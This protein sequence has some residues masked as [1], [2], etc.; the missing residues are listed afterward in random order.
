MTAVTRSVRSL[1]L[2]LAFAFIAAPAAR[3]ES[4]FKAIFDG[5]TLDGWAG[6]D[7]LW[8]VKDGAIVGSTKPSG[9]KGNTFLVYEKALTDFVLRIEFKLLAGNSGVQFRSSRVGN[10]ADYVISGYQADIGENYFGCL[11]D[12]KRRGMLQETDRAWLA[13]FLKKGEWNSYEIRAQG[14]KITL[15]INGLQTVE[16]IEKDDSM[17]RTGL[18]AL[19]LHGGGPMEVHFRNIQLQEIAKPKLLYVTTAAG[20]AHRSRPHSREVLKKLGIDSGLFEATTTDTTDLISPQGLKDFDAVM[21][22]TTGDLAQFPLSKENREYLIQWVKDGH[23]FIGVHSATDTYKDWQ[24]F[25]EMIG[26]SFQAHPWNANDPAITIDVE[27]PSHPAALDVPYGW[28]IQDEIYEFKNYA[29]S[30]L[31]IILSMNPE[32]AAGKGSRPDRDF[33][34]AW[35]REFGKGKVFY[36]SLGHRSDVWDNPIYQRHLTGGIGWALGAPGYEGDATPGLAKP[37]NQFVALFDGSSLSGW[38][39]NEYER[40]DT[41]RWVISD[42]GVVVGLPTDAKNGHGHL[43]SPRQYENFHYKADIKIIDGGNSGMYFRA[44]KGKRWPDGFEAQINST[45]GDPVRSGS[46]YHIHKVFEQMAK[47]N[48]WFT[49]E[50]IAYGGHIVIRVN[51]KLATK[52]KTPV[53]GQEGLDYRKGHFAF[54]FHDPKCHVELRNVMVREL[55][56]LER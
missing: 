10:P 34:I 26:G 8:S 22:Y 32:S 44:S 43:F 42:E 7:G 15:E 4:E 38:T 40:K 31:H 20:Y 2:F 16:Y 3:G 21:F 41:A 55:P 29:R 6:L 48:E 24:P 27:D 30:R 47:P 28:K 46:L 33:P 9:R 50:V 49:Q 51:G 23:G 13:P 37:S 5:K 54:Q 19:Q 36:T 12:E 14:N 25:W 53:A 56:S 11:Y 17:A 39:P 52:V 45:H 35:C 1:F 18:I